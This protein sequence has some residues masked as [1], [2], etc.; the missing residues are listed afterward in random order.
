MNHLKNSFRIGPPVTEDAGMV[1]LGDG[2][3]KIELRRGSSRA[4]RGH[5]PMRG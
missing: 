2:F 5:Q 1:F 3:P 4:V